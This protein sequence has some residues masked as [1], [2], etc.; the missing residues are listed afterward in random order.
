MFTLYN[1]NDQQMNRYGEIIKKKYNLT[2]QYH[3]KNSCVF[4]WPCNISTIL[5]HKGQIYIIY[6][7]DVDIFKIRE[8]K[9][10]KFTDIKLENINYN[11]N[12]YTSNDHEVYVI[13]DNDWKSKI[14]AKNNEHTLEKHQKIKHTINPIVEVQHDDIQEKNT[15][16][17]TNEC[18]FEN[19]TKN[20]VVNT[21]DPVDNFIAKKAKYANKKCNLQ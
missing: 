20:D 1:S 8:L 12:K 6:F 4:V 16:T 17:D 13:F 11:K 5:N 18:D 9:N 21:N 10:I 19:E 2:E 3:E 15:I 14:E 7:S